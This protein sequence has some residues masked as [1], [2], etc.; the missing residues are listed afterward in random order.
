MA[1]WKLFHYEYLPVY[2]KL[3]IGYKYVDPIVFY[4]YDQS[5]YRLYRATSTL[6][7]PS[8]SLLRSTHTDEHN[9][10]LCTQSQ[11]VIRLYEI[12]T[13]NLLNEQAVPIDLTP[14]VATQD[15]IVYRGSYGVPTL[16][17]KDWSNNIVY[18]HSV[19]GT[20]LTY[21]HT[22][23]IDYYVYKD[24]IV[25]YSNTDHVCT[26]RKLPFWIYAATINFILAEPYCFGVSENGRVFMVKLRTLFSTNELNC[27]CLLSSYNYLPRASVGLDIWASE[28]ECVIIPS[29]VYQERA[30]VIQKMEQGLSFPVLVDSGECTSMPYFTIDLVPTTVM[31]PPNSSVDLT[32]TITPHNNFTGTV[33]LSL[34]NAPSGISISPTSVNVL[35]PDPAVFT[36]TLII[37]WDVVP[38]TYYT[39]F[40][41][42]SGSIHEYTNLDVVVLQSGYVC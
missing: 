37:G 36:I 14:L 28:D 34:S 29:S 13:L 31:S 8:T 27:N 25:R 39:I 33:N 9:H 10:I 4:E 35:G 32:L 38:Y 18:E 22:T 12:P 16:Y 30:S 23:D 6:V 1:R 17:C 2:T 15:R 21:A 26:I 3:T 19:P 24:K 5:V 41:A 40:N 7:F 42:I 20:L 11:S